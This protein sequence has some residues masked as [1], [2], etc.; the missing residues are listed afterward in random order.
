[1]HFFLLIDL[2][3]SFIFAAPCFDD[4]SFQNS[5]LEGPARRLFLRNHPNAESDNPEIHESL[6]A[7]SDAFDPKHTSWKVYIATKPTD[8][9]L[10]AALDQPIC[11]FKR[12]IRAHRQIYTFYKDNKTEQEPHILNRSRNW[13]ILPAIIMGLWMRNLGNS[14]STYNRAMKPAS[15]GDCLSNPEDDLIC[16]SS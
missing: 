4:I 7:H 5:S 1:M 14:R 9:T 8:T 16:P 13:K 6:D 2:N 12:H 10:N 15:L 3:I 11:I